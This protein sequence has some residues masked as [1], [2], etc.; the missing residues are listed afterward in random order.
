MSVLNG[1]LNTITNQTRSEPRPTQSSYPCKIN[2]E[3]KTQKNKHAPI[4]S[5]A[6]GTGRL[7]PPRETKFSGTYG[8]WGT[9]IFPVQ[10]TTS[11]IGSLTLLIHTLLYVMTIHTTPARPK[12]QPQHNPKHKIN[13]NQFYQTPIP[14]KT[15]QLPPHQRLYNSPPPP[16][17]WIPIRSAC[18]SSKKQKTKKKTDHIIMPPNKPN[19]KSSR[20]R[21]F[22][23]TKPEPKIGSYPESGRVLLA[24]QT[25]HEVRRSVPERYEIRYAP[26]TPI[27]DASWPKNSKRVDSRSATPPSRLS[28]RLLGDT[29]DLTKQRVTN[30]KV[31]SLCLCIDFSDFFLCVCVCVCVC[32]CVQSLNCT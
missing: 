19:K 22:K 3:E 17:V 2:T 16:K 20:S 24:A 21:A 25:R 31:K 12:M 5:N 15:I 28:R 6:R 14:P 29:P 9:F 7:N 26:A 10:L 11:R 4:H 27:A 13:P 18:V 32:M 8:D 1:S 30:N 23:S